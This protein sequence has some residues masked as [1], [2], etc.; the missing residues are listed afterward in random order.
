MRSIPFVAVLLIAVVVP[1][2]LPSAAQAEQPPAAAR[3]LETTDA[4]DAILE[5]FSDYAL[6]GIAEGHGMQEL[7]ELYEAVLRHEAFPSRAGIVVV[8]FGS[9]AQQAVEHARLV[10]VEAAGED[11]VVG[12]LDDVDRVQLHVAQLLHE[13]ACAGGRGP[14]GRVVEQSLGAEEQT[15]GG[16][17]VDDGHGTRG[18]EGNLTA[19]SSFL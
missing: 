16:G 14:P 17:C 15:P 18:H 12:P 19:L 8:E 1:G 7:S 4:V 6:V 10:A 2:Q 13:L 5:L 9:G 11:Q 3:A